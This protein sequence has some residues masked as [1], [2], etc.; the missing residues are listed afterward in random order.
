MEIAKRYGS[1]DSATF[2][3]GVLDQVAQAGGVKE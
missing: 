2:I 3:N 1:G